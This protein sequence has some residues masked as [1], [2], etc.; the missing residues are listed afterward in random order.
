MFSIT[1]QPT[2]M[3]IIFKNS[4][5][6]ESQLTTNSQS[7]NHTP[8]VSTTLNQNCTNGN[9]AAYM[10]PI[11]CDT[12]VMKNSSNNV[13]ELP[14]IK[15]PWNEPGWP[16]LITAASTTVDVWGRIEDDSSDWVCHGIER[17]LE[18]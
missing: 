11:D 9:A 10:N 13:N 2:N 8:A 7:I 14:A 15:L 1:P 16:I 12:I 3:S 6:T 4:L 17:K 5:H 18:I